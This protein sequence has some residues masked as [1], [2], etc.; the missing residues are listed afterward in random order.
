MKVLFITEWYPNERDPQLGVFIQKHARAVSQYHDVTVLSVSKDRP[1]FESKDFTVHH[2][3]L[4]PLA[5]LSFSNFFTKPPVDPDAFDIVHVHVATSMVARLLKRSRV[6]M[7][8]SEHWSGYVDGRFD[9]LAQA[10]K[11]Q[12]L[13]LLRSAKRITAVSE[14]LAESIHQCTNIRGI[15]VVPNVIEASEQQHSEKHPR[16]TALMVADIADDIKNISGVIEAMGRTKLDIELHIIGDGP[17][18]ELM[19]H[20]AAEDDRIS[21]LGRLAN[22]D[23]LKYMSRCHFLIVNSYVETFSMVTAEA[24]LAG[25]PVIATHCG[26]PEMFV[27]ESTGILIPVNDPEQLKNAIEKMYDTHPQ[28]DLTHMQNDIV[29]S[30]NRTSV[31]KQFSDLCEEV[32][33]S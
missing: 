28:Y 9:A 33:N 31:G 6:P 10:E 18:M 5:R 23:V 14:I 13:A 26:G 25:L 20:L 1:I 2:F 19:Q 21:F 32:V 29:R 4:N 7:I 17:D 3:R 11:D 8:I 16:V 12:R 15:R 27:N 30:C 22:E 24:I